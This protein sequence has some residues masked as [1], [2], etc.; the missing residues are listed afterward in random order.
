MALPKFLSGFLSSALAK[1][2]GIFGGVGG[3]LSLFSEDV[4]K[5]LG[6]LIAA[7]PKLAPFLAFLV[8][9]L[10]AASKPAIQHPDQ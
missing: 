2:I 1:V 3:V 9:V 10:G 4:G 5:W 6:G 7:H 8:A